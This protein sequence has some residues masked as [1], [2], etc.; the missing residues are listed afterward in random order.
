MRL[1][2]KALVTVS[3]CALL[4]AGA[5]CSTQSE[6]SGSANK[7]AAGGNSSY[8]IT[9]VAQPDNKGA[10]LLDLINSA[11][12][13]IDIVIYQIGGPQIPPALA[14]AM[15]KGVKVRAIIDGGSKGNVA[16]GKAFV[17]SMAAAISAASADPTLFS[18]NWSSDNFN[19]THQKSVMVD[20]V[21]ANGATLASGS[22]PSSARLLISTGNFFPNVSPPQPFYG[23][24]DF[25]L[26]TPNQDLINRASLVYTSDF[27]C[28]GRTATNNPLP[29]QTVGP[30]T[31]PKLVWSNGTTGLYQ[32]DP[33]DAYPAVSDGYFSKTKQYSSSSTDQ[34]NSFTTQLALIQNAKQG[35]V[36]R[37]YNEEMAS[38]PIVN[39]LI[40]AATPVG[41]TTP[42]G[43][44]GQGADVRIV[45]SYSSYNGQ[46]SAF[47]TSLEQIAAAGGKVTLF[48]DQSDSRYSSVLYIHAKMITV[49][50]GGST[51]GF[52]GSENFSGG[53]MGFNRELGIRLDSSTD[54]SAISVLNGTFD[55]DFNASALTTQLTPQNPKNI[56]ADWLSTS[57]NLTSPQ[58]APN[59]NKRLGA[60]VQGCGPIKV[61]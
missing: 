49:T 52:A 11:T 60:P 10:A 9:A 56:P 38:T 27:S 6:Q 1:P 4:V 53:S 48:A 2:S 21:D 3:V 14:A 59:A 37:V 17:T 7:N 15:K 46:P 25:Y 12:K 5:G 32:G 39:A 51:Q 41:K 23:A 42:D 29:G 22:M 35:D 28:A 61:G 34:G 33:A 43:K 57:K 31:D 8:D 55:T 40:A 19:Y 18:A 54:S 44:P 16:D 24:R 13:S 45:M 20:A 30:K 58:A 47:V 50:S 36:V 26:T